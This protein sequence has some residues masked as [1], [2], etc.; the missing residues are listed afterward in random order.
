M[1]LRYIIAFMI[2]P[3][4]QNFLRLHNEDLIRFED[5]TMHDKS[6][7]VNN[8]SHRTIISEKDN[9]WLWETHIISKKGARFFKKCISVS[10]DVRCICKRNRMDKDQWCTNGF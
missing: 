8:E 3:Y 6:H 4:D 7:I 5:G 9:C 10:K 2:L 1:V